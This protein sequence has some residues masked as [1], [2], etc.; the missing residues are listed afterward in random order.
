MEWLETNMGTIIVC[1]ILAAIMAF[2]IWHMV[3]KK[4]KGRS[5]CG[6]S[7]TGCPMA[8]GCHGSQTDHKD[9]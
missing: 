8:G 9:T 5:I 7:C 4:R 2:V 1:L 3:R 6:C